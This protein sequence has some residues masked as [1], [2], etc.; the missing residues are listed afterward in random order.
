MTQH[1]NARQGYTLVELLIILVV[2]SFLM[3]LILRVP[4]DRIESETSGR[5]FLTELDST[6][7][8]AQEVSIL[9]QVKV[10]IHFD[11]WNDQIVIYSNSSDLRQNILPLPNEWQIAQEALITYNPNGRVRNYQRVVLQNSEFG[12]R[13]DLNFQLGSGRYSLNYT[14]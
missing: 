3:I 5:L 2:M 9:H 11:R 12:S 10:D 1:Q 6:I 8:Y 4:Y 14:K 13:I 7:K